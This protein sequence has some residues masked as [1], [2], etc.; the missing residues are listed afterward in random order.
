MLEM[1]VR[2]LGIRS[3]VVNLGRRLSP[4][5]RITILEPGLEPWIRNRHV[6]ISHGFLYRLSARI[7][8]LLRRKNVLLF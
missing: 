4:A 7:G 2:V 1:R 3:R 5:I 6:W 8:K